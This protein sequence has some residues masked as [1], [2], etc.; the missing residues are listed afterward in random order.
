MLDN[1]IVLLGFK[2]VGKSAIG[3]ALAEKLYVPWIDL[4]KKIESFYEEK[5]NKK[6]HCK[7]IMLEHGENFFRQL[8]TET[9]SNTVCLQ[10]AVISL[11]GGAPLCLEN[12]K[13]IKPCIC[14]HITAPRE[15]VF[16]R[17]CKEDRPA[18]FNPAETLLES[19]NRLWNER[20][21]VYEKIQDFSVVNN[22]SIDDCVNK[23][24]EKL[25]VFVC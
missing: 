13:I 14:I 22:H 23:I 2:S 4:D 8:E 5:F 21:S 6:Y 10:P 24:I 20:A 11:G 17:L 25:D 12:Q 3:N 9:L 15:I 16:E 7:Q 18:F 1:T 19:F